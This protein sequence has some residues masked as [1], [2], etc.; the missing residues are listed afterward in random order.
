MTEVDLELLILPPHPKCWYRCSSNTLSYCI[1]S[2]VYVQ[3]EDNYL[4]SVLSFLPFLLEMRGSPYLAE[5]DSNLQSS[6]LNLPERWAYMHETLLSQH[7][8]LFTAQV[9]PVSKA[10]RV[11]LTAVF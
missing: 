11:W 5:A 3:S 6:Y 4:K 9:K 7:D 8:S 10:P 1:Y 2:F